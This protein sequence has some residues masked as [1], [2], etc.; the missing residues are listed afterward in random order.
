MVR[1]RV[2]LVFS[3]VVRFRVSKGQYSLLQRYLTYIKHVKPAKVLNVDDNLN[4][5][6]SG[7]A[8]N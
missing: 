7:G 8:R 5:A 4:H 2:R 3:N 6:S 1:V